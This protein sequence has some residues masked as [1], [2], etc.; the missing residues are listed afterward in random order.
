MR[1]TLTSNPTYEQLVRRAQLERARYLGELGADL[2]IGAWRLLQAA[3]RIVG[4][5]A[6]RADDHAERQQHRIARNMAR[7]PMLA[8]VGR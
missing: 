6:R 7:L 1:Q 2:L 5:V 4:P 8:D 3:W